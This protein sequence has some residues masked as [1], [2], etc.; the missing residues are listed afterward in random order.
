MIRISGLRKVVLIVGILQALV[1]ASWLITLQP[2]WMLWVFRHSIMHE[3]VWSIF[4][5]Y[6]PILLFLPLL[7]IAWFFTEKDSPKRKVLLYQ[8]LG[9]NVYG[10]VFTAA[11]VLEFLI[12]MRNFN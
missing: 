8:I 5:L 4:G 1:T 3:M 7:L 12:S 9:M 10:V 2:N 6:Y 11:T